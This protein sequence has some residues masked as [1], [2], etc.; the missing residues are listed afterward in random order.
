MDGAKHSWAIL[1]AEHISQGSN[2][3]YMVTNLK[4]ETQTLYE[5]MYCARGK[6]ENRIKEQKQVLFPDLTSCSLWCPYQFRL[7]LSKLAY[8]LIHANR[9]TTDRTGS[10]HL[11]HHPLKTL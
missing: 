5:I 10:S 6:M 9:F 3:H 11:R 4:E 1:K 8:T 2:F 7:F